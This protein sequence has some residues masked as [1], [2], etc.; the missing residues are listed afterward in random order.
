MSIILLDNVCLEEIRNKYGTAVQE[1]RRSTQGISLIQVKFKQIL[2]RSK[3]CLSTLWL[4]AYFSWWFIFFL[5]ENMDTLQNLSDLEKK[6][7]N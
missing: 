4:L 6:E 3:K 5:N 2:P 7:G 1:M